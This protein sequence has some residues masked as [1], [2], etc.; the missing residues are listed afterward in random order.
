LPLLG[1]LIVT[2]LPLIRYAQ[3]TRAETRAAAV[4][5]RVAEAQQRFRL[6]STGFAS[7]LASLTTPCGL[8]SGALL[9]VQALSDLT[10]AGYRL[11][12]RPAQRANVIG[13]D[14]HGVETVSD[15]YAAVLPDAPTA[16]GQQAFAVTS[17]GRIYLFYDGLPPV[18]GD[19]EAGG[20]AT[21]LDA[22]DRFKIP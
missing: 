13:R 1:T 21:A 5:G 19:M 12:L 15:Y 11:L 7:T 10:D 16:A 4:L 2:A 18:E 20:L 17:K 22:A 8:P 9:D 6:A 3:K 14:C